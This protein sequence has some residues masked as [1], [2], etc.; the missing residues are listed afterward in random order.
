[1]DADRRRFKA[2]EES[3]G[4]AELNNKDT[5]RLAPQPKWR[6]AGRSGKS[7]DDENT[8]FFDRRRRTAVF[9]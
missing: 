6:N 7:L 1:M 9:S 5:A 2:T 8:N 3:E 4:N